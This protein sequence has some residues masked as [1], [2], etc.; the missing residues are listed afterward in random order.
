MTA[1][2]GRKEYLYCK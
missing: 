2:V 1:T